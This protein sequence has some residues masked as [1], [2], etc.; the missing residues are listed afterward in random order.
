LERPRSIRPLSFFHVFWLFLTPPEL[1]LAPSDWV[2][3]GEGG[4]EPPR[5]RV[6]L[7]QF[8]DEQAARA[9]LSSPPQG[10][11]FCIFLALLI[12]PLA[13]E[14]NQNTG[15]KGTEFKRFQT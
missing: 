10:T 9:Q 13:N 11:G 3:W 4:S 2:L 5:E 1:I 12:K 7:T 8:F 6:A 14:P 15:V